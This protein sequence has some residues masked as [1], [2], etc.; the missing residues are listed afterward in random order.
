MINSHKVVVFQI[1]LIKNFNDS[2]FKFVDSN[3][4]F[5]F[6]SIKQECKICE[7]QKDVRIFKILDLNLLVI[8]SVCFDYGKDEKLH[9]PNDHKDY[10]TGEIDEYFFGRKNLEAIKDFLLDETIYYAFRCKDGN[11]SDD[12]IS[13]LLRASKTLELS[14]KNRYKAND[15]DVVFAED[16]FLMISNFDIKKK[17]DLEKSFNDKF[18]RSMILFLIGLAYN[19]STYKFIEK[20][21]DFIPNIGKD[22]G[23]K[24]L[25]KIRDGFYIYSIK[26][27][28]LNPVRQKNHQCYENWEFIA[29]NYNVRE[30]YNES[31]R[32]ISELT[33]LVRDGLDKKFEHKLIILGIIVAI[34]IGLV[35]SVMEKYL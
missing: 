8:E 2:K 15:I 17:G 21:I 23:I 29:R 19:I 26:S 34:V 33:S 12:K 20:T 25:E 28:F 13:M 4:N 9:N 31:K 16:G 27:F 30:F 5:I 35:S 32:Q 1:S 3:H 10:L 24:E 6:D 22:C 14:N 11:L 18:E 7:I